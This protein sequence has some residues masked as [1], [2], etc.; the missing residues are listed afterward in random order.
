MSFDEISR[1]AVADGV[2][3]LHY[4][5]ANI[6]CLEYRAIF[7]DNVPLASIPQLAFTGAPDFDAVYDLLA[8]L[9]SPFVLNV[10]RAD[11]RQL[12]IVVEDVHTGHTRSF[13]QSITDYAGDPST[14][15]LANP[16]LENE[17]FHAQLMGLVLSAS[18]WITMTPYLTAYRAVELLYLEL[19]SISS[20][21]P[22]RTHP[23]PTSNFVFAGL[24]TLGLFTDDPFIYVS[25]TE[26]VD[27]VDRIAPSCTR[28]ELLRV[29]LADSRECLDR[30][31]DVVVQ[32]Y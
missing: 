23:F 31:F 15:A 9:R 4:L 30:R 17:E 10:T 14:N 18:L 22:T 21:D 19:D 7:I 3:R 13:V 16:L 5:W 2:A 25:G 20:L 12:M 8:P 1:D 11:A 24:R 27:F 32:E 28:L 6:S 26:L 29:L